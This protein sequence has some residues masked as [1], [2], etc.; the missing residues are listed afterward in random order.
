M[1]VRGSIYGVGKQLPGDRE[2][3]WDHEEK[4]KGITRPKFIS[5]KTIDAQGAITKTVTIGQF[6]TTSQMEGHPTATPY[7]PNLRLIS[8]T[9]TEGGALEVEVECDFLSGLIDL[10][11]FWTVEED[12]YIDRVMFC[13]DANAP[14]TGDPDWSAPS[15]VRGGEVENVA[16][17]MEWVT[18]EWE[19]TD[20]LLKGYSG[21][22]ENYYPGSPTYSQAGWYSGRMRELVQWLHGKNIPVTY[23]FGFAETQGIWVGADGSWWFIKISAA[24]VTAWR[25][26]ICQ[27]M[28]DDE[29][30]Y[31]G[32]DLPFY[33][34]WTSDA[35]EDL[36][37]LIS[38][39][40][41]SEFYDD[42]SA[43]YALCGWSFD[44]DGHHA[45]NTAWKW[46]DD[47]DWKQSSLWR[48]TIT[49]GDEPTSASME[50]EG[51]EYLWSEFQGMVNL[52][53]PVFRS[54][55]PSLVSF[56]TSYETPEGFED[57]PPTRN[58]APMKA[59]F[60]KDGNEIVIY[61]DTMLGG[62][63]SSMEDAPS[64]GSR[65][66]ISGTFVDGDATVVNT[67]YFLIKKDGSTISDDPEENVEVGNGDS[68]IVFKTFQD[69]GGWVYSSN[70]LFESH[71][72]RD[73]LMVRAGP[74]GA[75]LWQQ[76]CVIL[77]FFESTSF[78][79]FVG[80]VGTAAQ[81]GTV[82]H[83][84][85]GGVSGRWF[86]TAGFSACDEP[87][88]GGL[89]FEANINVPP[90]M[91]EITDIGW[92]A[93]GRGLD[94]APRAV[95]CYD[96]PLYG[97]CIVEDV[98]YPGGVCLTQWWDSDIDWEFGCHGLLRFYNDG[99]F[100]ELKSWEAE[101]LEGFQ[102]SCRRDEVYS[103]FQDP[104]SSGFQ[105]QQMAMYMDVHH[106]AGP[107]SKEMDGLSGETYH[108]IG[109]TQDRYPLEDLPD[110]L[111][112]AWFGAPNPEET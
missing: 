47:G 29:R 22:P 5:H 57:G 107:I 8:M 55:S 48:L 88:C 97:A 19:N 44:S 10:R 23:G 33:P 43:F 34:N 101:G 105:A 41:M 37:E 77:P 80:G 71:W 39:E 20:K 63:E 58:P 72:H 42:R 3:F 87:V 78:Y 1:K 95:M 27:V 15:W 56:E 91:S 76:G 83:R 6:Y 9:E 49:G 98:Y 73:H 53:F 108:F 106:N 61:L 13:K 2:K 18:G 102:E 93:E 24:G 7:L 65:D 36:V 92:G 70:R 25:V 12:G 54:E 89:S 112:R 30:E 96:T 74:D 40:D 62:A 103:N 17:E 51:E 85:S 68:L 46:D 111:W 11:N 28:T 38:A 50:M 69:S 66:N 67:N 90:T 110:N 35:E 75:Y 79:Y 26:P 21:L 86:N 4:F 99:G 104:S 59:L 45:I 60:D 16:G 82:A 109:N 64:C 100:D 94:A 31:Y 14:Q 84:A 81:A 52:K 32:F